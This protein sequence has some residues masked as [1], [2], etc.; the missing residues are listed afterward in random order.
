M[1]RIHLILL[2]CSLLASSPG[3]QVIG[4]PSY[5]LDGSTGYSADYAG[6]AA[7]GQSCFVGEASLEC[8]SDECP[9][10]VLPPLPGWLAA[11]KAKRDLPDPPAYPRFH[12]LPTRP[13]FEPSNSHSG[14]ATA[15]HFGILPDG[16]AWDGAT[17]D[18]AVLNSSQPSTH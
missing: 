11:W 18:G 7:Q 4:I 1:Q 15:T 8:P 16:T 3:C 9:P 10:T 12:P 5:R 6:N 17:W 2:V 13:M 14:F